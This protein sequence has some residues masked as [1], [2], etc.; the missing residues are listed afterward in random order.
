MDVF[1]Y[2]ILY[3]KSDDITIILNL[4]HEL[5]MYVD[6]KRQ[7]HRMKLQKLIFLQECKNKIERWKK[8]ANFSMG[9]RRNFYKGGQN[10]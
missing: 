3:V 1:F 4:F 9:A 7:R 6:A 5:I 10:H 2:I 8:Q